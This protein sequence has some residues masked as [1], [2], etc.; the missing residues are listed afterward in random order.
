MINDKEKAEMKKN[1]ILMLIAAILL[2]CAC[3]PTD[4]G[5][6]FD[7]YGCLD[8]AY[9]SDKTSIWDNDAGSIDCLRITTDKAD[10]KELLDVIYDHL[11]AQGIEKNIKAIYDVR[12]GL[13]GTCTAVMPVKVL[14]EDENVE[15]V[16]VVFFQDSRVYSAGQEIIGDVRDRDVVDDKYVDKFGGLL[17]SFVQKVTS[18]YDFLKEDAVTPMFDA[19]MIRNLSF[20]AP[21]KEMEMLMRNTNSTYL[22]FGFALWGEMLDSAGVTLDGQYYQKLVSDEIRSTSDLVSKHLGSCF[23]ERVAQDLRKEFSDLFEDETP[24][25]IDYNGYLYV[26]PIGMGAAEGLKLI[27]ITFMW[28]E[29]SKQTISAAEGLKSTEVKAIAQKDGSL[30]FMIIEKVMVEL[31]GIFNEIPGSEQKY[32]FLWVYEKDESGNWKCGQYDD[33]LYGRYTSSYEAK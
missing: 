17:I 10:A 25:Y 2:L 11:A 16:F 28:D 5:T 3:T 20:S 6:E 32:E 19:T 33:I 14:F 8:P 9:A 13:V 18:K 27:D 21:D 15:P 26:M 4:K 23:T 12:A 22:R 31:D 30:L 24:V 1:I 7:R 29:C